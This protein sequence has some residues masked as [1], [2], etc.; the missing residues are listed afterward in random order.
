M[1]RKLYWTILLNPLAL[2]LYAAGLRVLTRLFQWG[3]VARR[4]PVLIALGF[5]GVLWFII[6]T[7][8]YFRQKRRKKREVQRGAT[9]LLTAE[10]LIFVL[11]TG[12]AGRQIYESAQ[13]YNGKLSWI[14]EEMRNTK[15]IAFE[16][17]DFSRYGL[18]GIVTALEEGAGLPEDS[19]LYTANTFSVTIAADGQIE[20]IDGYLYTLSGDSG[21]EDVTGKSDRGALDSGEASQ[22]Y[23]ITYDAAESPDMTVRLNGAVHTEYSRQERM[24]PMFDMI[25]AL[26]EQGFSGRVNDRK[27]GESGT[28]GSEAVTDTAPVNEDENDLSI[29]LRYGGYTTKVCE[30]P[31]YRLDEEGRLSLY[32][33]DSY[34]ESKDAYVLTVSLHDGQTGEEKEVSVVFCGEDSMKTKEEIEERSSEEQE[35]SEA[36]EEGQTLLTDQDGSMTFYLDAEHSMRLE[37]T[38]AAAGSR[39]YEFYNGEIHNADPFAG[40]IGVAEGMYFMDADTGF[41]LLGGA[42]GDA[43]SMYRTTDGGQQFQSV[44]L[45]TGEAA[46]AITGNAYGFTT[47]DLDY[48]GTPYEEDGLLKVQVSTSSADMGT[49]AVVFVSEDAGQSWEWESYTP[50]MTTNKKQALDRKSVAGL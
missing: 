50:G 48:I 15:K 7:I 41:I 35:I 36:R 43:S 28:D 16:E 49:F 11:L 31:W 42:S 22:S 1:N 21:G 23:L 34:G 18:S 29:V 38:D 17:R 12:Y 44:T 2:I 8:V 24:Q 4:L 46:E 27:G 47:E 19:E 20:A 13:P 40:N 39:F 10:L 30:N 37:V 25:G 26:R 5:A 3:G 9:V 32:Y 45:P 33:R 14:L 6:W